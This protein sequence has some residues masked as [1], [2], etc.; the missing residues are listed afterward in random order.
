MKPTVLRDLRWHFDLKQIFQRAVNGLQIHLDDFFALLAIGFLNGL[1]D[2]GDRLVARQ[3][4]G[5]GEETDLHD[6]V[7]APLHAASCATFKASIT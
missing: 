6:G 1:F 3:H 7:D 2:G 4:A 5:N